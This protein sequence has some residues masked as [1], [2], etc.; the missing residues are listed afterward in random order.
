VQQA[1]ENALRRY[2]YQEAIS[3]FTTGLDLLTTLPETPEYTQH[4]LTLH[5]A[6]GTALLMTKGYT[7]P[8]VEQAYTQAYALCQQVGETPELVSVLVGL[9]GFH[10]MRPQL[11][12]ARELGDTMLRLA[13][14]ADD[15]ALAVI[16]HWALGVPWLWRGAFPAARQHLEEAIARYTPD[17]HRVMV[18]RTGRDP[19][20]AC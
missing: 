9:W 18:L 8:E 4:A 14:P 12:P 6:L 7:A 1:A 13:Q 20:V 19:G 17:Q 10:I 2:A 16:A 11:H 5:I 15:P 3:H